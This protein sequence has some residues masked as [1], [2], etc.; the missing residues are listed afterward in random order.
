MWVVEGARSDDFA[1]GNELLEWFGPLGRDDLTMMM[2]CVRCTWRDP[3]VSMHWYPWPP[4]SAGPTYTAC[5]AVGRSLV[6]AFV[7]HSGFT[8]MHLAPNGRM[9]LRLG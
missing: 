2:F 5:N 6:P 1:R 8:M 3:A 7:E 9:Y 4:E